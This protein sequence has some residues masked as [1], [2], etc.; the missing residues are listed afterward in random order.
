MQPPCFEKERM[1]ISLEPIESVKINM[2]TEPRLQNLV[3]E[4]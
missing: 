3:D 4:N 2:R 1:W